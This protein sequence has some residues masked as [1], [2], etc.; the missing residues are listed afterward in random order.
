[1]NSTISIPPGI[2]IPEKTFT[3]SGTISF[4]NK[5]PSTPLQPL[6]EVYLDSNNNIQVSTVFFIDAAITGLNENSFTIFQDYSISEIGEPRLQFFISYDAIETS[7]SNFRAYQISFQSLPTTFLNRDITTIQ[8]F[9]WDID[10]VSS[11]G[12]VT[13]VQS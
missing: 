10:P 2:Q 3:E 6:V 5:R 9:L 13:N 11:R 4:T 1:M 7:T 8:T 12:T